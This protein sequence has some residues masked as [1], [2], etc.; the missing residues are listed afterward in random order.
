MDTIS[1]KDLNLTQRFALKKLLEDKDNIFLTG[2]AGTGKSQVI[3]IF[4]QIKAMH[5]INI[6]IVASTGAAALL[7]N[8]ITF[9]SYFGLGIMSGGKDETINR[10]MGKRSVCER[11][12]YTDVIIIDEISMISGEVFQ[13]AN[14]LCQKIRR[15][16][17]LFGGIRVICVGDFAQLG[18]YSEDESIDWVF[19]N[20]AWK[21]G[22]FYSI[23]LKEVMRTKEKDFL[24]IL[25]KVREGVVDKNVIN[26]L[27]SKK[28]SKKDSENFKGARIFSRNKEV[29]SYNQTQLDLIEDREVCLETKFV[30]EDFAI[31]SL[32]KNLVIAESIKIKKNALVMLRVNN[33]KEGYINGTMGHIL[34]LSPGKIIIQR[35]DGQKISVTP[36]V[37]EFR[38]GAGNLTG[39]AK[40]FPITLAWA[41][42]I[43][44]SQGASLDLAVMSLERLWLPGQAYTALSRLK[45]SAGLFIT[46]WDQSSIIADAKVINF[47]KKGLIQQKKDEKKFKG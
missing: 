33:P 20:P 7:V 36:H 37:F 3:K 2:P 42:T 46:G 43:Q 21:K 16:K 1:I 22:S 41:I 24:S 38:N 17:N 15:N 29:D 32:K 8:G 25:S 30:G 31:N 44:K 4:R 11:I 6:P 5:Q 40:N 47:Y 39:A 34:S 28:I 23:Q 9:N 45:S 27:N 18:P 13:A 12:I 10:A 14:E 19:E 26:F 35:L